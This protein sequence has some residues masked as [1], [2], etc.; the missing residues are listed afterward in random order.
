MAVS[1]CGHA[2]TWQPNDGVQRD[3]AISAAFQFRRM[4]FAAGSCLNQ[5]SRDS[6]LQ[7]HSFRDVVQEPAGA[8]TC[9]WGLGRAD[10]ICRDSVSP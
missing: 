6:P 3:I 7:R 5:V 2:R 10:N 4:A 1:D 8:E 9:R